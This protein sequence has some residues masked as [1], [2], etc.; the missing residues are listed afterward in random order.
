MDFWVKSD[1]FGVHWHYHPELEICYVKQGF[2]QRIVGESV[3]RFHAGDLVLLGS[4]LPHSWISDDAFAASPEQMEVYVIHLDPNK[5]NALL[6]LKEFKLLE[7]FL[8]TSRSGIFF[9]LEED[10]HLWELLYAFEEGEGLHKSLKL[11]ELLLGMMEHKGQRLLCRNSY[12]PETGK[13]VESRI[14]R[15]CLYIH[16][17]YKEKIKLDELAEI[18]HMNTSAFCRFFKKVL[19]KTAIEYIHE[20]RINTAT[21]ELIVSDKAIN[22]IAMDNGFLSLSQFNKLFKNHNQLTPSA[23]RRESRIPMLGAKGLKRNRPIQMDR[24]EFQT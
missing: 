11:L 13:R 21:H 2:G 4:N 23:Y 5:L 15:V 14:Q 22:Q 8:A 1:F 16:Q 20:L 18:A 6:S 10:E 17:H 12:L 9:D 3:E 19:G 24:P 7:D